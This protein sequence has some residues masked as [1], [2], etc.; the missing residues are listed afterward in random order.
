MCPK[1]ET[2]EKRELS[3][4]QSTKIPKTMSN[5]NNINNDNS[6]FLTNEIVREFG[7]YQT[8]TQIPHNNTIIRVVTPYTPTISPLVRPPLI[9]QLTFDD[10]VPEPLNQ[11]PIEEEDPDTIVWTPDDPPQDMHIPHPPPLVRSTNSMTTPNRRI[12]LRTPTNLYQTTFRY[13]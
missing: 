12:N 9:R 1:A 6:T 2:I 3:N 10:D 4:D 11:D 5:I 8:P 7:I 13:M